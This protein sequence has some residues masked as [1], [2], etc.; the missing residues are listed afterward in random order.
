MMLADHFMDASSDRFKQ[1][2]DTKSDIGKVGISSDV[3]SLS[4]YLNEVER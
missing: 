4:G 3:K 1:A 2:V